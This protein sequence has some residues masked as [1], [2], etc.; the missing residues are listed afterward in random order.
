MNKY[1][2]QKDIIIIDSEAHSGKEYGG[3]S[4]ENIRRPMVVVSS[5]EYNQST[6]MIIGMPIISAD[7]SAYPLLFKPIMVTNGDGTGIKGYVIMWQLQNCDF[8]ARNGV[9]VNRVSDSFF[10]DLQKVV[11]DIHGIR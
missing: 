2:K 4:S 8:Y 7:K 5:D 10:S 9:I 1:S 6:G 11:K 3:H